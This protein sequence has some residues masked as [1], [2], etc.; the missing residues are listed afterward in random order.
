MACGFG[1]VG[2]GGRCEGGG[3]AV[4]CV[5]VWRG[6]KLCGESEGR[7]IDCEVAEVLFCFFEI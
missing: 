3:G 4:R 1:C 5:G 2:F 6:S 7:L